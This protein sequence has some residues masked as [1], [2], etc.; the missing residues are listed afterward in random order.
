MWNPPQ[1]PNGVITGYRLTFTRSGTSHTVTTSDDE[2]FHVIESTDIPWISGSFT[3]TVNNY[4]ICTNAYP[5][6]MHCFSLAAARHDRPSFH[7]INRQVFI[8]AFKN[9]NQMLW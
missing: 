6:L 2:T 4:S 9:V 8:L 1:Q 5:L 3:V 7:I